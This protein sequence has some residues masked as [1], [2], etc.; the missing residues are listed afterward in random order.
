M[1]NEPFDG[2]TKKIIF[3]AAAIALFLFVLLIGWGYFQYEE[4]RK[5]AADGA[6][7]I[8]SGLRNASRTDVRIPS[9]PYVE[10]ELSGRAFGPFYQLRVV[11][12]ELWAG[13]DLK[14]AGESNGVKKNLRKRAIVV[15]LYAAPGQFVSYSGQN[16]VWMPASRAKE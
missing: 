1:S 2:G 4:R 5:A 11:D 12:G 10:G 13:F 16:M 8:I 6:D 15:G 14:T 9:F 7:S 3:K